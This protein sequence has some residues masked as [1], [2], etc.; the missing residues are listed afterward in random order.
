[1]QFETK[2]NKVYIAKNYIETACNDGLVFFMT[3]LRDTTN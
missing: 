2:Y 3:F 1:M